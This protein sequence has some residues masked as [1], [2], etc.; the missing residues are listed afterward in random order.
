VLGL[1]R[2]L[3]FL[4]HWNEFGGQNRFNRETTTRRE[5]DDVGQYW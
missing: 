5:I 3:Q 4:S 1:E 2:I